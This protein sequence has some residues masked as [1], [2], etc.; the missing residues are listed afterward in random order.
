M[1]YIANLKFLLFF[2]SFTCLSSLSAQDKNSTVLITGANRGLGLEMAKQFSADGYHVIGTAR[3]PERALELKETGVK[4]IQLDVTNQKSIDAM[5]A[6]L[7]DVTID[8]LINNAGY[9]GPNKIGTPSDKLDT[10]TP[11]ELELCFA[12]NAMGPVFVTQALL[13]NLKKSE[14]KKLIYISSRASMLNN[15]KSSSNY[16]YKM[17]KAA[18]NMGVV[19]M[20]N[21]L[22]K[23]NFIVAAI[24]PGH[25]QTD[26]G[27]EN[28]K[29]TT[30]ETIIKV[31]KLIENLTK[32]H[33]G[34]LWYND[35]TRLE[36]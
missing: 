16:G 15:S 6:S 8:I 13:P 34:A 26:M 21:N 20:H 29:L 10:L 36:W 12:V 17:S 5:A 18:L 4:V 35:G 27:G 24:A 32:E 22:K 31:K 11:K 28:A 19:V 25:T 30:E 14:I 9:F 1:K 7:K 33:S 23:K 2:L 3:S